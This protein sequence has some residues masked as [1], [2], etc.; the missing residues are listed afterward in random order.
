VGAVDL[1]S[2]FPNIGWGNGKIAAAIVT[3][4]QEGDLVQSSLAFSNGNVQ[5]RLVKERVN[6]LTSFASRVFV[7]EIDRTKVGQTPTCSHSIAL[8]PVRMSAPPPPPPTKTV[9]VQ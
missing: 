7:V 9:I 5:F 4:P 6:R 2:K 1:K 8:A 3:N